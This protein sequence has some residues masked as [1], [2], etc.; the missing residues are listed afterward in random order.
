MGSE[1]SE[2]GVGDGGWGSLEDQD[3][4]HG[5]GEQRVFLK[6]AFWAGLERM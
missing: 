1:C 5:D 2:F 3:D 6:I 4:D